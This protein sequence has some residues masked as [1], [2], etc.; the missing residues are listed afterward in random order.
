MCF[1]FGSYPHLT[2]QKTDTHALDRL[3]PHLL[4]VIPALRTTTTAHL[5]A[6]KAPQ[7]APVAGAAVMT[8][9][10][11]KTRKEAAAA[12]AAATVAAAITN[13]LRPLR[14]TAALAPAV[15][16]AAGAGV[17]PLPLR[18]LTIMTTTLAAKVATIQQARAVTLDPP[19]RVPATTKILLPVVAVAAP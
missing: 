11:L 13:A 9:V 5:V 2:V 1:R 6:I 3:R 15:T 12:A 18:A 10:P 7:L 14:E 17:R 8:Q 19:H 16:M 4:A